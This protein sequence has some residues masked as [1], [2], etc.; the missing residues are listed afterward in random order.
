[1]RGTILIQVA[2][3]IK[4]SRMHPNIFNWLAEDPCAN[5]YTR[6]DQFLS[7][8]PECRLSCVYC[9][10]TEYSTAGRPKPGQRQAQGAM[11]GPEPIGSR[12]RHS[13]ER[14]EFEDISGPEVLL[15][16]YSKQGIARL[17]SLG[18]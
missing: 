15:V 9:T 8:V 18:G 13:K 6:P 1:M 11:A 7:D 4:I 17:G 3:R 12:V 14:A 16:L 2:G 10:S 5:R